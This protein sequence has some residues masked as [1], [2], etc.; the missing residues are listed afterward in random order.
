M[1]QALADQLARVMRQLTNDQIEESVRAAIDALDPDSLSQL[2]VELTIEALGN[3]LE[4]VLRTVF[5]T[6]AEKEAQRILQ[7]TPRPGLPQVVEEGIRLPSGIIV[8]RDLAPVDTIGF[9]LT[10]LERM[11]LDFID[12][13]AVD[14]ARQR[15]A[16]R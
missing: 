10:P 16:S 5:L 3:R 9:T 2:L 4:S 15:A 11:T 14:Y 8:P 6:S 7:Q 12:P 13:R 1:E